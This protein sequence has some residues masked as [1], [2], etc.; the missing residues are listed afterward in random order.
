MD[1]EIH[2]SDLYLLG[3]QHKYIFTCLFFSFQK[4]TASPKAL[5]LGFS[6]AQES[7]QIVLL[8][9]QSLQTDSGLD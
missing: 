2:S 8:I 1:F 5:H 7:S 4:H 6:S 3:N 9:I